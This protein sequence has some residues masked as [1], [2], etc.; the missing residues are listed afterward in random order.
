MDNFGFLKDYKDATLVGV[1]SYEELPDWFKKR[2]IVLYD[3]D[4]VSYEKDKLKSLIK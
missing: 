1:D 2:P 3:I 4:M